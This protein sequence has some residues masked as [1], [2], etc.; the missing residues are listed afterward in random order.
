MSLLWPETIHAGLF[1][2]SFWLD[3]RRPAVR[4]ALQGEAQPGGAHLLR[5]LE[6]LITERAA[7]LRKGSRLSVAV[8]DGIA[9]ISSLPWQDNLQHPAELE[10]YARVWFEKQGWTLDADW[11]IR[12]VF[13]QYRGAGIAYALPR[14]WLTELLELLHSR[15]LL[16][17]R[18]LPVTVAAYCR[19]ASPRKP[20]N[21]VLLLREP[22]R[23][24]ALLYGQGKLSGYSVEPVTTG[25]GDAV[26]RLLRRSQGFS[27]SGGVLLDWSSELAERTAPQAGVLPSGTDVRL[28]HR[29]HWN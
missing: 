1:P 3:A 6:A 18:V 29:S 20:G 19:Q 11:V 5:G 28:L 25:G 16:L 7:A 17:A 13:R 26:A 9:K 22:F 4:H 15:N 21:T 23:T 10:E 14:R 8:S 24:S 2:G 12:T 27:G